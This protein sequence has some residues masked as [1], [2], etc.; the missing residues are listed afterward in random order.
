MYKVFILVL[1]LVVNLYAE[2]K[3]EVFAETMDTNGSFVKAS[4]DVVVVYDGLYVSAQAASYD[5][6]TG[7]AYLMNVLP[8]VTS[9]PLPRFHL[10]GIEGIPDQKTIKKAA[11]ICLMLN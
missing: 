4:D 2:K 1:L 11:D 6:N 8:K 5:H 3:V 10:V 9:G 7:L